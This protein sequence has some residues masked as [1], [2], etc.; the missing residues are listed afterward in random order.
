MHGFK[1]HYARRC[2]NFN[3]EKE[4]GNKVEKGVHNT[5]RPMGQEGTEKTIGKERNRQTRHATYMK[6]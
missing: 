1:V 2:E 4:G 5:R 6:E 3:L